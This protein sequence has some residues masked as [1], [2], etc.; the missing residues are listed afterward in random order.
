MKKLFYLLTA[1]FTFLQVS[2][3]ELNYKWKA[4][5]AYNFNATVVD[6]IST[7][8][9]GMN[10]NEKYTTTID[11]TLFIQ[12]VQPNGNATGRMYVTNFNVK[13]STGVSVASL[14]NLPK[15]AVKSEIQVDKKGN[16]TFLKKVYLVTTPTSNVLVYANADENSAS[17]GMQVGEEKVDAYAEFDPKTG[18][19]KAG[20]SV[21][22]IKTPK[23]VSVNEN[24][25]SDEI[26]IF[27][28]DFLS[29]MAVPEG[30]LNVNDHFEV[31][32]GMYTVD[33]TVKSATSPL[34]VIEENISTDKNADMFQGAANGQSGDGTQQF[35]MEG[36]GGESQMELTQ[37]D[38]EAMAMT[39][40]AS[41]NM[42][43][44][45]TTSF[46]YVNGM[47]SSIKGNINT[48]I[49][50][51]GVTTKVNSVIEMKKK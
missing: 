43:G 34:M 18:K 7:S 48:A 27:P 12:S 13:N 21:T 31:K 3:T 50:M 23:K 26:D 5:T 11:F 4:N 37:E 44:K 9:M 47:F 30:N 28:Y 8:T 39:K 46:D 20:Y 14:L 1:T 29:C 40:A 10:I 6:N 17:A 45:L 19:L 15:D 49:D 35:N 2:A 33:G 24:E 41:P 16:F 42:D 38:Q 25:E 22:T 51:M 36:F 32:A